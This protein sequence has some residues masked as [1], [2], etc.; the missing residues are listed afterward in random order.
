[1]KRIMSKGTASDHILLSHG[2]GGK[3][4]HQLVEE[5]FVPYFRNPSLELL[6]D[7]TP[8]SAGEQRLV[9]TTDSYVVDPLFFPGGDIGS[10]AVSGTVNDLLAG[11]ARPAYLSAGFILEEGLPLADLKRI[12]ASMRDAARE[13]GVQ[14]IAGDTKVVPRGAADKIFITTAGVGYC[15]AH[16]TVGARSVTPGDVIL[17]NGYLGDHGIA[18]MAEREGLRLPQEVVSDCAPLTGLLLPLFDAELPLHALR[19]PTRG[20]LSATLNEIAQTAGVT[21]EIDE[22][23]LPVRT[24]VLAACEILGFDPLYLANEG[25]MLIFLPESR[26]E[27]ALELLRAHPLGQEA[28]QIGRVMERGRPQVRLLTEIGGRRILDMPLAEQLPRIC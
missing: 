24:G 22:S 26:A 6:E 21:I 5:L 14:I 4:T 25:K 11:G 19:D 9:M 2:S 3:L 7:S 8:F 17:L 13:A 28:R 23:R 16:L 12:L 10:L 15:R 1:M 18:V 27:Q 20:G